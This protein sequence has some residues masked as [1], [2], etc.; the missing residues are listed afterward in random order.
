MLEGLVSDV[1]EQVSSPRTKKALNSALDLFRPHVLSLGLRISVLSSSQIELLLPVKKRNLD[2]MERLLPGV[3]ISAAIE[4]YKLLWQRNAPDGNF[5]I[6]IK[7]TK[8]QFFKQAKTDLQLRGELAEISRETK[9]AELSKNKRT[10]HEMSLH[11]FDTQE[12]MVAEIE[13]SAELFV[14]EMIDWK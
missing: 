7:S 14:R 6:V 4:A 3:Q 2:E 5:D 1:A 9:W 12:Q 10:D 13:I 11:F 8:A